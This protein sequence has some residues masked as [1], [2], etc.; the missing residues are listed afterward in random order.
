METVGPFEG[1]GEK[2]GGG[3]EGRKTHAGGEGRQ[4]QRCGQVGGLQSLIKTFCE[5]PS[6]CD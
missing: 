5:T 6:D 3:G 2:G 1:G 4:R